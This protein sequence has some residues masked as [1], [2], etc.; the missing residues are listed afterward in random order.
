MNVWEEVEL[1][2]GRH[3][4][5]T[6]WVFKRKTDSMGALIKYKARLCAQGFSKLEGI[7]YS[8]TYAP[9]GRL[10]S[11][12]TCLSISATEDYK[13]IQMDAA[14]A[15]LNGVPD[16]ILYVKPPKGYTCRK[17]GQNIVL[18]LK[19]SLYGLKQ[20]PRCWYT[21]LK[22]FFLSINFS[23]SKADPCV[24]ISTDPS[25]PCG[26]HVHVDDLCIMG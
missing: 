4:L 1:P 11:L 7:D 17:T 10:A 22:E 18:K 24:F 5:G 20:S 13:V 26:V 14:G 3:A 19:K 9:T 23:P 12:R 6:T 2:D 8:D 16:E 21:Q 15:F 25:W